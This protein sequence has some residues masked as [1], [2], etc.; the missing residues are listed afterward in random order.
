MKIGF[1]SRYD[2]LDKKTWSGTSYYTYKQLQRFG[3]IELFQYALPKLLQEFLTTQKSINRRWF[4]KQTAVEFLKAY[5]KYFSRQLTKDLKKRPVDI[6]FVSA[7]PQLI[8]YVKTSIPIVYMTDATFQQLQGYYS[9]FSN[10]AAYNIRQGIALDKKAF[11]HSAHCM[12]ASEWNKNSAV[13]EYGISPDKISVLPCGA[14]LDSIPSAAALITTASDKCRFL[15]LGVEWDRKGGDIVLATFYKLK[16]MGINVQLHII[17]CVPPMD[18][19]EE[20][21]IINIP[22]LDKNKAADFKQLHEIFLQTDFLLLPTRAECAGVVFSEAA[23]YGI[24]SITTDTG[25]VTTYVQNGVNGY[26]LSMEATGEMY[27]VTIADLW[28]DKNKLAALKKSSRDCYEQQ[29]NWNKW[30]E[31][32]KEIAENCIQQKRQK[33]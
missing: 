30:G 18:L 21:D 29:L 28:N 22:F 17:G 8:A 13:N 10:L 16:D 23:A 5:A 14:N 1:A 24:P 20:T 2:P 19:A 32:F 12:L 4:K 3:D 6:L 9:S 27:A 7:S 26:K 11:E 31:K 25:G 33:K 15:F